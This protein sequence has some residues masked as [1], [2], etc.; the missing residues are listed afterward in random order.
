MLTP[1]LVVLTLPLATLK[2]ESGAILDVIRVAAAMTDSRK[3]QL[4]DTTCAGFRVG[5]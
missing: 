1:W 2:L 5:S 4:D 3:W